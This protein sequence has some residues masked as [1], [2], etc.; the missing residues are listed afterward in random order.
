MGKC[1]QTRTLQFLG[2]LVRLCW[3]NRFA[4]LRLVML[5]CIA[6]PGLRMLHV[7]GCHC[8]IPTDPWN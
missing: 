8:F 4:V 6:L 7:V 5:M 1:R 2:S 3:L